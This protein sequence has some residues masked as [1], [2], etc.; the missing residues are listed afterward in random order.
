MIGLCQ[1]EL[2]SSSSDMS[3]FDVVKQL[4]I[5]TMSKGE[6]LAIW[7]DCQ[8]SRDKM[9]LL[10]SYLNAYLGSWLF[11]PLRD[12]ITPLKKLMVPKVF[13]SIEVGLEKRRKVQY[14]QSSTSATLCSAIQQ[15]LDSK[16]KLGV[17][18]QTKK[19]VV[20]G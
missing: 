9:Y 5:P 20:E 19:G 16:K 2:L 15:L 7:D 17:D 4:H 12:C 1:S 10:G 11:H 18:L 13:N 3:T 8:L 14:W 6:T